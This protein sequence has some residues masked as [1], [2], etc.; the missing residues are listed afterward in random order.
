MGRTTATILG[1]LFVLCAFSVEPGYS[2]G[3][4][5]ANFEQRKAE[6]LR[7][8]DQRMTRLRDERSC[9]EG[10]S[11]EAAIK[12]CREKLKTGNGQRRQ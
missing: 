2:A 7:R 8:L 9:I 10:A 4:P 6:Q 5:S 11:N 12:S 1:A 3:A